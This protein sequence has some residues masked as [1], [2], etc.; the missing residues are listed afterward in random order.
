MS[1]T[2]AEIEEY[3][4]DNGY[5]EHICRAGRDGLIAKWRKFVEEVERGY[6]FG[7][8]EYRND[9]DIR[10]ILELIESEGEELEDIDSRFQAMLTSP[11]I[12]VW[13]SAPNDLSVNTHRIVDEDK[14]YQS[15]LDAVR[16][17]ELEGIVRH[18]D[19][20]ERAT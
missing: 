1:M 6:R 3:L 5:P 12:R 4:R 19:N 13:E 9:L 17:F 10:A 20:S 8:E 2:E 15:I 18:Y 14:F 16:R 11:D 7:L